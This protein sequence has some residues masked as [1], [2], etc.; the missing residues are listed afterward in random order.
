MYVLTLSHCINLLVDINECEM[1]SGGCDDICIN[2]EGS[3]YCQCSPG[4]HLA[5]D[6]HSC[7]GEYRI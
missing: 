2:T 5:S 1:D 4:L 6:Q 3:Y 7:V